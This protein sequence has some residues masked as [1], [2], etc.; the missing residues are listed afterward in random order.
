MVTPYF[1]LRRAIAAVAISTVQATTAAVGRV[2]LAR[3]AVTTPIACTSVRAT[4]AGAPASS[5]ATGG[6]CEQ[7][8]SKIKCWHLI[9][10]RD[11]HLSNLLTLG[12]V[13][14]NLTLLLLTRSFVSCKFLV[15][16]IYKKHANS[17]SLTPSCERKLVKAELCP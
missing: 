3:A 6:L 17:R 11:I 7:S 1:F 4:W 8:A 15:V 10:L 5:V 9:Q 16:R 12:K 13:Q 2:H 14:V